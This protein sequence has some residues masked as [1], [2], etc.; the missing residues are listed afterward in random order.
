VTTAPSLHRTPVFVA[1][2]LAMFMVAVEAT[3]VA[4]AM[5][6]IVSDL[7]GFHL[8]SWVFT[9]YLLA[10]A[11][12]IPIYGRLADLHG[13]RRV[14]FVGTTIFLVGSILCGFARS[15]PALIVLRALQGL[16]AGAV[17]PIASTIVGDIY[18]PAERARAQ[19]W[20]SGMFGVASV[21][22]P[23][24]GALLVERGRWPL[25]FWMNIPIGLA[26][27]GMFAL[28]L[29]ER[30]TSRPHQIDY[31]GST[32]LTVGVSALMLALVQAKDLGP[33]ALVALVAVG[34]VALV[35]LFVHERRIAEPMLP[36]ALWRNPF[37]AVGNGIGL[38]MGAVL[39]GINAFLPTYLQGVMG[40][41]PTVTGV[42]LAI[43]SFT[44][45][46][47]SIAAARL[48]IR[49]SY[50]RTS[51]VGALQLVVG[52]AALVALSPE[53]GL[54]WASVASAVIGGG[55]GFLST[56]VIVSVQ[57]AVSWSER[58][59]ATSSVMFARI[60]GQAVGAAV[61][62]AILNAGLHAHGPATH[63]AVDRLMT[64]ALRAPLDPAEIPRLVQALDRGLLGVWIAGAVVSMLMV[65]LTRFLP[66]GVGARRSDEGSQPGA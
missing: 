59:V 60:V 32:M 23:G 39:M 65:G 3:I 42:V 7:G 9:A 54:V 19:A 4:T 34:V 57:A 61:F 45:T 21:L 17:Q 64:P 36:A 18:A 53:H 66:G 40:E 13:R 44:W 5:P 1:C 28:Y 26:A 51:T 14:F 41:S 38:A 8:F 33:G 48:M 16:G 47:G 37:I 31:A 27:M 25:I 20:I 11:V 29:H 24:I 50:R 10:T 15:M 62:G 2:L 6:T 12:T 35:A 30:P 43:E 49:S 46:A 55:M 22:G 56:S 58:A 63:A 52:S